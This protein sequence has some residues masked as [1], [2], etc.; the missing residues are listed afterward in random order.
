MMRRHAFAAAKILAALLLFSAMWAQPAPAGQVVSVVWPVEGGTSPRQAKGEAI[1][2]ALGLAGLNEALAM[3]PVDPPEERK[4]VL[5]AYLSSRQDRFVLSYAEL[6]SYVATVQV[7]LTLDVEINGAALKEVLK[8][9]G[10]FATLESTLPYALE[11]PNGTP[12]DVRRIGELQLLSGLSMSGE[13]PRLNLT[14]Q[15]KGEGWSGTLSFSGQTFT[16][17]APSL[18]EAWYAL[19]PRYFLSSQ[20]VSGIFARVRLDVRGK[21]TLQ[22][23]YDLDQRLGARIDLLE[24]AGLK[25]VILTG[26][27]VQAEWLVVTRD[28]GK[29]EAFVRSDPGV[30]QAVVTV[31]VVDPNAAAG[32]EIE[33][34]GDEESPP[35]AQGSGPGAVLPGE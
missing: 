9:I 10:V 27:D 29:V 16:T 1:R 22:D 30:G 4:R 17:S 28:P 26:R 33:T 12:E 25:S 14:R 8:E 21:G 7:V 20:G 31:T 5:E 19:W 3:L 34:R 15:S 13:G 24:E 18:E 6:E 32:N 35:D 11:L 2:S 23:L